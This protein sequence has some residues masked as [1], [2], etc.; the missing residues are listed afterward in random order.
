MKKSGEWSP[1][2]QG[3]FCVINSHTD[4]SDLYGKQWLSSRI[5]MG[6]DQPC[7]SHCVLRQPQRG[8]GSLVQSGVPR[9]LPGQVL[10]VAVRALGALAGSCVCYHA[11]AR[12]SPLAKPQAREWGDI[13]SPWKWGKLQSLRAKV[14]KTGSSCVT[15]HSVKPTGS[16]SL[17][18]SLS[19]CL[20]LMA[21]SLCFFSPFFHV[22]GHV[23]SC[24]PQHLNMAGSQKRKVTLDY[25]VLSSVKSQRRIFFFFFG[26][27]CLPELG[28]SVW[29]MV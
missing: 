9:L 17:L 8:R 22:L 1:G 16:T 20:S 23:V 3:H 10:L 21:T 25:F 11:M 29:L 13:C 12:V 7:W 19:P 27:C 18:P 28:L 2:S 15:G 26:R 4:G 6:L 14:V 24:G 5:W